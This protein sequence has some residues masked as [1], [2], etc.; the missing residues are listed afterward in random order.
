MKYSVVNGDNDVHFG[1]KPKDVYINLPFKGQQSNLLKKQLTRLFAKLAP[2]I[3][4]NYI[5][6]AS[7]NIA[8][9]SKLKS[10]YQLLNVAI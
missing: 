5:F 1:P 8:K 10:V 6:Y 2:W 4:L 3:K 7:N 9:L